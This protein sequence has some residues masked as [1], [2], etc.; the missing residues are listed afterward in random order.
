MSTLSSLSAYWNNIRRI[1]FSLQNVENPIFYMLLKQNLYSR[2]L[3]LS[4]D[5]NNVVHML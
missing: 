1:R 3:N 4:F 5:I 2:Q